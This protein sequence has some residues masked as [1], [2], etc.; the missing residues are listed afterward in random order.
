MG[1]FIVILLLIDNRRVCALL[2]KDFVNIPLLHEML[3][4]L[5]YW[6]EKTV[7]YSNLQVQD[8][9]L[10]PFTFY[11]EGDSPWILKNKPHPVSFSLKKILTF[12]LNIE[13]SSCSKDG[14]EWLV[15]LENTVLKV[16]VRESLFLYGKR[17]C[18]FW[19]DSGHYCNRNILIAIMYRL[20]KL[21]WNVIDKIPESQTYSFRIN[22]FY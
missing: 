20:Y 17:D 16:F 18:C 14:K 21:K 7:Q 5:L 8:F 22:L 6:S 10:N 12:F 2:W 3:H 11:S 9:N 1:H 13:T 15:F 19:S 4:F